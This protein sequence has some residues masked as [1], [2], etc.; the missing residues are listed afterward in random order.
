V[1]LWGLTALTAVPAA[2][3]DNAIE[4]GE[5]HFLLDLY[6]WLPSISDTTS[7]DLPNSGDSATVDTGQILDALDMAFMGSAV[8]RKG[9]WSAFTDVI[10][11]SLS[12][13][14]QGGIS[15]PGG[16]GSGVNVH[17][18][19]ELQGWSWTLGG[20]YTVWY[21]ERANV[22]VL[23]GARLLDLDTDVDLTVTGPLD[24]ELPASL[25]R[26]TSQWDGIV[27]VAGRVEVSDNWFIPYYLDVGTGDSEFTSEG[28]AGVGYAFD[29]GDVTLKYRYLY[30]DNGDDKAIEDLSFNGFAAG[31][32]FR[33]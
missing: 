26:S 9:R 10:Y 24:R 19:E 4:D 15:L 32:G 25:S 7:F 3:A 23:V 13:D 22:D 20:A 2:A 18:D 5:W 16:F 17:V 1:L 14:Q 6:A 27:G 29:W 12:A 21:N 33:F 8:A 31:V 28:F 11:L 30:Y